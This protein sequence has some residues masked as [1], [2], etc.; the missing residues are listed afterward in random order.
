MSDN[1]RGDTPVTH[2]TPLSHDTP[3]SQETPASHDPST[4]PDPTPPEGQSAV[5]P[6]SEGESLQEEFGMDH[7]VSELVSEFVALLDD[8]ELGDD[9]E[10]DEVLE[11]LAETYDLESLNRESLRDIIE[12]L[13]NQE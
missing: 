1:D 3:V 9:P 5:A 6:D 7:P 13:R 11:M 10:L 4:L 2:D 8:V 12:R